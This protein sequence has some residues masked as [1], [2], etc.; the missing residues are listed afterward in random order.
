MVNAALVFFPNKSIL[1]SVYN[2]HDICARFICIG[3][4][5]ELDPFFDTCQL[6]SKRKDQV[7]GSAGLVVMGGDSWSKGR[8]FE[9]ST[10]YWM[11]IFHIYLL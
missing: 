10:V 9:S 1:T 7:G 2:F 5:T 4:P 3:C 6:C 11:D 8:G